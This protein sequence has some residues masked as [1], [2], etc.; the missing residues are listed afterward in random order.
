MVR[1]Q[2]SGEAG[3]GCSQDPGMGP[4]NEARQ[5][6]QPDKQAKTGA[7]FHQVFLTSVPR[8][9]TRFCSEM[10]PDI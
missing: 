8:K 10:L 3:Q 9:S 5:E 2:E 1:R 6:M 7:M 4:A